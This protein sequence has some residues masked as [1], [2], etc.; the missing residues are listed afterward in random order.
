MN[1]IHNKPI[2]GDDHDEQR[3]PLVPQFESSEVRSS[4]MNMCVSLDVSPANSASAGVL[5]SA[6]DG[7]L[8]P[9]TAQGL[10]SEMRNWSANVCKSVSSGMFT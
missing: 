6:P 5:S 7:Y 4:G 9:L 8:A 10:R 3:Q 2:H 1:R